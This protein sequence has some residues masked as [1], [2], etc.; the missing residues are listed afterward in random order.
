MEL[1]HFNPPF[2]PEKVPSD[3]VSSGDRPVASMH[4]V[5]LSKLFHCE[6]VE[7]H[8]IGDV[9]CYFLVELWVL[10]LVGTSGEPTFSFV[11]N[12]VDLPV[13]GSLKEK[14]TFFLVLEKVN[15][16]VNVF[17]EIFDGEGKICG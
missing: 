12:L 9:I 2:L 14:E 15:R 16:E 6:V 10:L 17:E 4:D 13:Q 7:D 1:L 3:F 8:V 5:V 11:V